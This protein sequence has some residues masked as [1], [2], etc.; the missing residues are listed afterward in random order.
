MAAGGRTR[1]SPL[2]SLL[3]ALFLLLG[4]SGAA[5]AGPG[6]GD[7]HPIVAS[8]AG[9]QA[10]QAILVLHSQPRLGGHRQTGDAAA[11]LSALVICLLLGRWR[12]SAAVRDVPPAAGRPARG[13]RAPPVFGSAPS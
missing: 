2:V 12:R 10:P 13:S 7:G 5:Q 4:L 3:V 1:R 6:A 9:G 11:L 8:A